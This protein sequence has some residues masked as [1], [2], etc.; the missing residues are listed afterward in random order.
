MSATILWEPYRKPE[1][2]SLWTMAPQN[3][4]ETL[5][6]LGWEVGGTLGKRHLAALQALAYQHPD[7]D[8]GKNPYAQLAEAIEKYDEVRVWAEY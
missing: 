4:M 7:K 1:G 5:R 6:H 8:S 2:Q 3:F